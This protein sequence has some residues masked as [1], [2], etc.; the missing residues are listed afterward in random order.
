MKQFKQLGITVEAKAFKGD[1]ITIDNILN[2]EIKV[3]A[4]RIEPSKFPKEGREECLY[5]QIEYRDELRV[6]F[7]V[8][9]YLMTAI[10]RVEKGDFPFLTTII[11]QDKRYEFT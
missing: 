2:K 3:I 5:L 6:I 11:K 7:S 8:S 1:K 4:Y 10:G 9:Q